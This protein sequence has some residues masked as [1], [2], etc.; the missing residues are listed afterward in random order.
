MEASYF[1][2]KYLG[3]S[4]DGDAFSEIPGK[5]FGGTVTDNLILRLPLDDYLPGFHLAPYLFGGAG[6]FYS[7]RVGIP[8]LT[9]GVKRYVGRT[10]VLAS[11]TSE[12]LP[13][14]AITLRRTPETSLSRPGSVFGMRFPVLGRTPE[15]KSRLGT[16]RHRLS[17]PKTEASI[18]TGLFTLMQWRSS[19]DSRDFIHPTV[20][21]KAFSRTI[22]SVRL[23]TLICFLLRAFG[24]AARFIL[25][26]SITRDSVSAEN[27]I[28]RI[29]RRS[30]I[31]WRRRMEIPVNC[32][33]A[34]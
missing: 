7:E 3:L 23:R 1:Y 9:P 19:R 28:T 21:P 27:L 25:T 11:Q 17:R 10:G 8:T 32:E 6:K 2:F 16:T 18:K 14:R 4:V 22:I 34:L 29:D 26:R 30:T 31:R 20:D 15:M 33:A 24:Q 13:T 5:N 12:S